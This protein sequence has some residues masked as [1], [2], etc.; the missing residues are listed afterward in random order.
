VSDWTVD[1]LREH[2]EALIVDH[3]HSDNQRF[4]SQEEAVDAALAAA[5]KAV[6]KA[7]VANEKRFDSVNE[8]RAQ[9]NDQA[10]N[11]MPRKEY[12]VQQEALARRLTALERSQ[13][14]SGGRTEGADV[15]FAQII[16]VLAVVVAAATI[17]I[18]I[19]VR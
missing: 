7:E 8:F 17:V 3:G 15:R 9:L 2:L 16:S 14:T 19:V 4:L 6:T 1:T 18:A 5:E 12:E 10:R 11:F 13:S